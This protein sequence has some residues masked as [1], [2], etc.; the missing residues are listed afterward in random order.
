MEEK[1]LSKVERAIEC[2][3]KARD[4]ILSIEKTVLY[5][6]GS[7][8]GDVNE[9]EKRLKE[10][11]R[12]VED[13]L[14]NSSS[15]DE[16]VLSMM[17][18]RLLMNGLALQYEEIRSELDD[19]KSIWIDEKLEGLSRERL[20][21]LVVYI[22]RRIESICDKI[23]YKASTEETILKTARKALQQEVC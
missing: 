16:H 22:G 3:S 13:V 10:S 2:Q 8:H 15:Q 12:F 19:L 11:V 14:N 5:Q 23:V 9:R 1:L 7:C 18:D 21:A 20:E 6:F 4:T 17:L